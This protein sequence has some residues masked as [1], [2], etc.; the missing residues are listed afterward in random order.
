MS[1][2]SNDL[3]PG[4]PRRNSET[5]A[6]DHA[7]CRAICD[8]I[9]ERLRQ[10]LKPESLG[11]PQRLLMLLERLAELEQ[12][13][14]IVPSIEEMTFQRCPE[15]STRSTGPALFATNRKSASADF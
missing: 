3:R 12:P 5:L 15:T 4:M 8:E 14:S 1:E 13:P 11:I 10:V 6:L 2:P 7:H 9:G